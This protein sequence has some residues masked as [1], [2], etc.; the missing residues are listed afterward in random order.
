MIHLDTH[1]A[2][3]LYAGVGQSRI[4]D[5]LLARLE[6]EPVAISPMAR[7]ELC[8]LS[9]VGRFTDTPARLLA[10]L[11]RAMQLEVDATP[12]AAVSEAAEAL[13]F[14]RDPFDRLIAAQS[15]AAGADLA[16]KDRVLRTHLHNAVWG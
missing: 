7:L 1:V 2:L 11:G 6:V 12:F 3:W 9:E 5:G 10:E 4:P 13:T 16:T 15:I 8:L 14:T